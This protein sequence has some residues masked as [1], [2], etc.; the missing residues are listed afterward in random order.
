VIRVLVFPRAATNPY[1]DLLYGSVGDGV[2]V[3]YYPMLTFSQTV[4]ILLFPFVAAAYR[5]RGYRVLHIHWSKL[6]V[7]VWGALPGGRRIAQAWYG[8][9]LRVARLLGYRIVWT[10]HNLL[11]LVPTFHDDLAARRQLVRAS[12]VVIVHNRASVERVEALGARRVSYAP[13]GPYGHYRGE[14]TQE[15]ARRILQVGD[16]ERVVAFVGAMADY[17]GV[18]MLLEATRTLR[19]DLGLRVVI[20]GSCGSL[21]LRRKLEALM[22]EICP[23]VIARFERIPDDELQIYLRA[24][25]AAALPFRY[26]TNS[27]SLLLALSFGLPVVIPAVP[28]LGEVPEAAALRYEPGELASLAAALE[29]VA[30][31]DRAKL[32]AMGEQ[33]RAY[34]ASLSWE[35]AARRTVDAYRVALMGA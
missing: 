9:C 32:I 1:Q 27:T 4:N 34:V 21:R 2:E 10:A 22:E 18:D 5:A 13:F 8:A 6:F 31:M 24:A 35:E 11:P 7:P 3:A 19:P 28:E 26:I 30:T 14:L 29:T 20:A 15:E 16:R 12:S 25:D 33:A 17:K 23:P